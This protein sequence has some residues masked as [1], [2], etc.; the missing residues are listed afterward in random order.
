MYKI[1]TAIRCRQLP[2]VK[3]KLFLIMKLS[4]FLC[5]VSILQVS[6]ATTFAQKISLDKSN[7]TLTEALQEIHLQSGFSVF[8]NAKMLKNAVPVNVHLQNTDLSEVLKQCF[9]NQPF[10]Y[11]INNNTIVVTP[12]LA[13]AKPVQVITITGQVKDD[14]GLPL[15]G[16]SI[17]IKGSDVGTQT[18]SDGSYTLNVPDNNA[19]LVFSF[20]GFVTQEVKVGNE[21]QINIS[22]KEQTSALN[23]IVVVGYGTQ[24]K[25]NLTGA[26]ST[27]S[28]ED[29]NKRP[30]TNVTSMLEGTMPGVKINTGAG[31]PGNESVSIRIRGMGSYSGA[32]LEPL[33]LIDGVQGNLNDINPNDIDNVSVLKDAA[34][35]SIYGSRGANG[36][37]LVTTKQGKA[38]KMKV[39]YD[40]NVGIYKPTNMYKLITNS[41]TYMELFNEAH[42]NSGITDPNSLYPQDQIDLYRNATDRVRYPNTDWLS[43][44]FQTAPT[45][46]HNLTFS[47]GNDKTV[48]NVS[49]GYIDQNGIMKGFNYKKYTARVNLTSKVNDHIK[50]GTNILL[51]SGSRDAV[52]GNPSSPSQWDGSSMDLFLSAMSQA[53]TYGPYLSDGSGHYTFKA[54]DFEYNNKNPVAV[55]DKNFKRITNDYEANAQGWL[56]VQFNKDFSWYTKGAVNFSMD[57]YRDY[58]YTL[59]EYNFR[60]NKFQTSLDLGQGLT[61]QDEQTVYTNLY[62]YLNYA[63][64]FGGHNIKAQ[65]GY[66]LE[67]SKWEYLRGY[68]RNFTDPT[69]TQLDAGGSD[70]QSA[71]GSENQW[72]IMSYFG[73][74]N[75]NYKE[76]YLLEGNI[77]YDGSSKFSGDNK[78][79]VFPSFSAGW[80][81]T[82][83]PFIKALNL[84]WLTNLKLRGSWG[85][86]GNQNIPTG[87]YPYQA[88]L[89]FTG[90]YSFD[91]STLTNGVAQQD[92]NNPIIKWETTTI[93]DVGLDVTLF[94][95]LSLTADW[96]KKRTSDIIR[97]AQVTA[98]VGLN[99][100]VINDGIVDNTG[101]EIGI[102]YSNVIR[103]GALRGFTYS[104][105]ANADH[106]TNKII[107]IGQRELGGYTVRQNG[108]PIDAFYTLQVIGIFQTA[109]EVANSPKQYGDATL[110]GD[111]KYKDVD[112]NGVINDNDRTLISG[113]FPKLNYS[114]NL[115]ASF[116]GFDLSAMAQGVYGVKSYV[117][118][119]GVIPFVQGTPPTTEWLNRWTPEHPS[120][121]LP[122]IYWGQG[123]PDKITRPSTF[124]LQN[125]SYL[126]IKNLVFGYTL[127][128]ATTKKIGL[129]RVRLY[130]SGD[131]LFTI[132]KF[133]GLDPERYGN[134]DGVQ[135]PQNK[136]YSFGLNVSF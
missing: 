12:K 114:F 96:Y 95:N 26:V 50:F 101:F 55:L 3:S 59:D 47:G 37:L 10:S 76:R 1:S 16:V 7:A 116:K 35:A 134:G 90:N 29:L 60:T 5:L 31:E 128:S 122:R 82:E 89:G 84:D 112:N 81:A 19:V 77:R 115:A 131:N 54:Y 52:A 103:D 75:Y 123:A 136:I 91:N 9:Q 110:P 61:D 92:L 48:Y 79:G 23:E 87:N 53:P 99:P 8:Y 4:F 107:S 69:L 11:V 32:D 43:L 57:K 126:R 129:D 27:V 51:K 120:T 30:V 21:T 102:N 45:Q 71:A 119:W 38:G 13:E 44:I 108:L 15:P 83:E 94:K 17:K 46:N 36:V 97:R 121:T 104:L 118:G 33:V 125:A 6:A 105:G 113:A 86:V 132:T 63:H 56:E 72:A 2:C 64:D 109:Q 111:L 98:L 41:A 34:S 39:Q 58:K 70:I 20:V 117:S 133:K 68:R 106:F 28:G 42:I 93:T 65:F 14:K 78:W 49:L 24:K 100:P 127:P 73:R 67:Q 66:S 22:L 25:V 40:G 18:K 88:V 62:S 135:Y 124:F 74:L 85:Q 130:F 80:R